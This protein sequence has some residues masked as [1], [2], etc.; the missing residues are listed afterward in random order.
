MTKE[1][2]LAADERQDVVE[3]WND[4]FMEYEKKDGVVV[5]K[6]ATR[7]VDTG[8]GL[9]RVVM[10]IQGRTMFLIRI[11]LHSYFRR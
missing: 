2:Y 4:V 11:F 5:G 9:E 10:A 8:S 1:E 6:L 7:N 3:I